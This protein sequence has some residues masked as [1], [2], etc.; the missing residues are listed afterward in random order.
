[1]LRIWVNGAPQRSGLPDN[2][3]VALRKVLQADEDGR[4]VDEALLA[5]LQSVREQLQDSNED[6][7]G[8]FGSCEI[9]AQ[10]E[11]ILKVL[12]DGLARRLENPV[13]AGETIKLGTGQPDEVA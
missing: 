11:D 3:G 8:H 7:V 10:L 4:V 12:K 1:M 9:V 2:V 6:T 5:E 13:E